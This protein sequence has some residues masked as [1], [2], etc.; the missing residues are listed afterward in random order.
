MPAA[1]AAGPHGAVEGIWQTAPRDNGAYLSVRIE[2]CITDP[3]AVC[4]TVVGSHNGAKAEFVGD[5][6]LVG[7]KPSGH[8]A[9]D[10][11][12]IIRPGR[13][14]RYASKL[15]LIDEGLEVSGCVAA[16]LFCGAQIWTRP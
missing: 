10:G 6:I 14:T 11:G 16:G 12:E 13:G 1:V 4:G 7:M 8:D 2:A 15:R 9:W 3:A 5:P